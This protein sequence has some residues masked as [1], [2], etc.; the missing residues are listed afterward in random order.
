[1][2][3]IWSMVSHLLVHHEPVINTEQKQ[4]QQ[5]AENATAG[6]KKKK[7]TAAQLRVQKGKRRQYI[8]KTTALTT[9]YRSLGTHTRIYN[10]DG[11]PRPRQHPIVQPYHLA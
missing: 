9:A 4:Q 5:K 1:M 3:K 7:V 8:L 10:E 2:L 11:I 6:P